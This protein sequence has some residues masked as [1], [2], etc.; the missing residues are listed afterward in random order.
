MTIPRIK[1][2]KRILKDHDVRDPRGALQAIEEVLKQ[3][4]PAAEKPT[5]PL[6]NMTLDRVGNKTTCTIEFDREK[7]KPGNVVK[8]ID[9]LQ[10]FG[11]D[12]FGGEWDDPDRPVH[13]ENKVGGLDELFE[14]FEAATLKKGGLQ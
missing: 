14:K 13:G 11:S 8:A 3:K 6:I 4:K 2:I 7:L 10:Q 9:L 12:V 1:Q 5:K